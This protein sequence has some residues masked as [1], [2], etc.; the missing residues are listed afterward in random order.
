MQEIF[1]IFLKFNF[2]VFFHEKQYFKNALVLVFFYHNK[3]EGWKLT[4]INMGKAIPA[5]FKK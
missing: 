2:V 5:Q 4:K 3:Y 1:R